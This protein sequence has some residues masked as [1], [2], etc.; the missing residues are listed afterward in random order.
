M[1]DARPWA[2]APRY[3]SALARIHAAL[4]APG[5]VMRAKMPDLDFSFP[6]RATAGGVPV[7]DSAD[8]G[9]VGGWFEKVDDVAVVPLHGVMMADVPEWMPWFGI[10]ATSTADVHASLNFALRDASIRAV[11]LDVDS[12]GGEVA[13]VSAFADAVFAARAVKPVYAVVRDCCASAAY[14]VASQALAVSATCTA[15]VGSI[16]VYC[17]LDDISRLY[18]NAG[19]STDVFASGPLKA[20][21]APGT[22]LTPAQRGAFQR[23]VDGLAEIFVDRVARRRGKTVADVDA[24]ATGGVWLAG[25]AKSLGLIDHVANPDDAIRDVIRHRP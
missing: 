1:I 23:G 6:G 18:Q 21:G 12:P 22:S 13:G 8:G 10:A 16:G 24:W 19:V 7:D 9:V 15:D 11:I 25:E 4:S 3:L 20:A 2:I 5:G 17:S 14:W